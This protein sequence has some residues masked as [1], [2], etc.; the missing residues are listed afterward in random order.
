MAW[1]AA[2]PSAGFGFETYAIASAII[3]VISNILK[4][5]NVQSCS[6]QIVTG[7]LII[8]AVT[9]DRLFSRK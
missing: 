5:M 4:L 2:E 9:R 7:V 8:G 1:A 6:L 3:G